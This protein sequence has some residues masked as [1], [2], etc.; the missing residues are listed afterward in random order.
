[1][2]RAKTKSQMLRGLGHPGAPIN[3]DFKTMI[4]QESLLKLAVLHSLFEHS[5]TALPSLTP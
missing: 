4:C 2:T 1:M 5:D 3:T